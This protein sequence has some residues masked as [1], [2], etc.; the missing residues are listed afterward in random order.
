MSTTTQWK[1]SP[2]PVRRTHTTMMS[3]HVYKFKLR[4]YIK[5]IQIEKL[6]IDDSANPSNQIL[7]KKTKNKKN[8]HQEFSALAK[9][10]AN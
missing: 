1:C 5:E 3:S 6:S 7:L 10:V 4:I 9:E 8:T 2:T